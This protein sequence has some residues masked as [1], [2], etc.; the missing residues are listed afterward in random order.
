MYCG[1]INPKIRGFSIKKKSFIC[2]LKVDRG[3]ITRKGTGFS[4]N[5]QKGFIF[6]L[7]CAPRV[8]SQK[9]CRGVSIKL[10][11]GRAETLAPLVV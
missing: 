6:L 11:V 7:K 4:K 3:L 5:M 2:D 10:C 9:K 1:L 8:N